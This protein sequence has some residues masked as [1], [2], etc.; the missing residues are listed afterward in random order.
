MEIDVFQESSCKKATKKYQKIRNLLI[1]LNFGCAKL[2]Q[3]PAVKK[4]GCWTF[5]NYLKSVAHFFIAI[6]TF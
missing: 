2:F 4:S 3:V 1:F 6:N 5:R